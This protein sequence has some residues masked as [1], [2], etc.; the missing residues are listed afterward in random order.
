MTVEEDGIALT[1]TVEA[2]NGGACPPG[3][4]PGDLMDEKGSKVTNILN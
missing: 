4:G 1:R 3:V 2:S